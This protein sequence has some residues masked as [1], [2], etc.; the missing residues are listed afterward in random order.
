MPTFSKIQHSASLAILLIGTCFA[1][2]SL[3]GAT[4]S[5]ESVITPSEEVFHHPIAMA[6][7]ARTV[8]GDGAIGLHLATPV[9]ANRSSTVLLEGYG[10]EGESELGILGAGIVYRRAV[11]KRGVVETSAFFEG[12]RSTDGF[13]YPQ[14]GA[15]LGYSPDTWIT[16][17]ANGYLP[18]KGKDSRNSGTERW[19]ETEGTG[20][21]RYKESFSRKFS[22]ERAPMRGFDVEVEFRLPKP[23]RWVDPVLAVGYAFREAEDRPEV[24]SGMTVRGELHFAKHWVIEGEWRQDMHGVNQEW[25]AGVR[26]EIL[27]GGPAG[28]EE[29]G[30]VVSNGRNG[31]SSEEASWSTNGRAGER[32][33]PVKR[34]PWPTLARGVTHGKTKQEGSYLGSQSAPAPAKSDDC[35]PS[36]NSP[37]IFN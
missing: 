14:L 33:Q 28:A 24:Y 22:Y 26:F 3:Q 9:F 5:T 29:R 16:F 32:Y 37:L 7:E 1:G 18:L 6:L 20:S 13:S 19:S 17:R 15:G 11:G 12:L 4:S 21:G 27:F 25:R 2:G 23:P 10:F 30:A 35:C 31:G 8:E 36:G 34:F